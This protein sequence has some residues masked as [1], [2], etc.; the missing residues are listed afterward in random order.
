MGLLKFLL[1]SLMLTGMTGAAVYIFREL[2]KPECIGLINQSCSTVN[3]SSLMVML[4]LLIIF[5]GG[6]LFAKFR[7]RNRF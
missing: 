2:M 1:E 6:F 3:H 5:I 7:N 4:T